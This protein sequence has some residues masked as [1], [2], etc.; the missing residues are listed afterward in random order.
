[1]SELRK[2]KT[3]IDGIGKSARQAGSSL[4]QF[5]Q[6]FSRQIAEVQST[7]GGSAQRKDVEVISSFNQASERVRAATAALQHAANVA[8]RYGSSL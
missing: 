7:I 3:Q 5:T 6:Q 8:Q 1:M 4:N 2:L